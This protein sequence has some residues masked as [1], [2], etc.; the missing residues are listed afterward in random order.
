MASSAPAGAATIV[1]AFIDKCP[2]K[3]KALGCRNALVSD[4]YLQRQRASVGHWRAAA[5]K[6]QTS[7]QCW[8]RSNTANGAATELGQTAA[9]ELMRPRFAF[10]STIRK[11]CEIWRSAYRR[12]FRAGSGPQPCG[13]RRGIKKFL[14]ASDLRTSICRCEFIRTRCQVFDP[15]ERG[16]CAPF[17]APR[18]TPSRF[19]VSV[20]PAALLGGGHPSHR[21]Y[22][23]NPHAASSF[24][25]VCARS[26][27][28]RN[29]ESDRSWRYFILPQSL[30]SQRAFCCI[31]NSPF[32]VDLPLN[33][34]AT[35]SGERS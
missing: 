3:L 34:S 21:Q 2:Q 8:R 28:D 4:A 16:T 25:P 33:S 11:S 35:D 9:R 1:L 15:C 22:A 31:W 23:Q 24:L 7:C 5:E 18:N 12:A 14:A 26:G 32:C 27:R 30:A 19:A 6:Q 13:I 20:C 17:S 29:H 10:S